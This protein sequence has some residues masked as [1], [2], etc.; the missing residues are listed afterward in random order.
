[1]SGV[2]YK[3][4]MN[5]YIAI[6][7]NRDWKAQF[8]TSLIRLLSH[9]GLGPKIQIEVN[10]MRNISNLSWGRQVAVNE[11]IAKKCTH[12]LFIDDDMASRLV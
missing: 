9:L 7:S 10:P 6:P 8:G 2:C 12:L 4:G 11:S 5:L 3:T 1:M